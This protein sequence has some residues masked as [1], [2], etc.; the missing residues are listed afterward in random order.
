MAIENDIKPMSLHVIR[1]TE[2]IE[3]LIGFTNLQL[4]GDAMMWITRVM[5]ATADTGLLETLCSVLPVKVGDLVHWKFI[6]DI[7]AYFMEKEDDIAE[8]SFPIPGP[9]TRQ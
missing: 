3:V 8:S 7:D 1:T 5:P 2:G 6:I 9:T 4:Y